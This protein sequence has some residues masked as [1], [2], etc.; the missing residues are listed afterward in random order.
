M[1]ARKS[2]YE[3]L[4]KEILRQ[5]EAYGFVTLV[6]AQCDKEMGTIDVL[7]VCA[8]KVIRT[9]SLSKLYTDTIQD[10]HWHN[11]QQF[12]LTFHLQFVT[13]DLCHQDS[14]RPDGRTPFQKML[15]TPYESPLCTF[16]ASVFALI[17]DHEVRAAKLPNR[18]ITCWWRRAASSDEHL[19]GTKFSSQETS[20]RSVEP[21]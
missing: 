8:K 20:S 21:P 15:G 10:E 12:H 2:G 3:D 6:I 13:L 16:G 14:V 5:F 7:K 19:V 1:C 18:W 11:V 9:T 4:T 17:R